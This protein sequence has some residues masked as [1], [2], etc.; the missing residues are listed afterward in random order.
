M[1]VLHIITGLNDGGAEGALF[2][3]LVQDSHNDHI[4]IS[5]TDEGK[6]GPLISRLGIKVHCLNIRNKLLAIFAAPKL[7][8]LLIKTQ[9]DAIQTWMYH[10]DLI[11]GIC[12]RLAGHRNIF[13]GIRNDEIINDGTARVTKYIAYLCGKLSNFIPKKII[14]C[15][16]RAVETHVSKGYARKKMCV[17]QNGFNL[18]NFYAHPDDAFHLRKQLQICNEDTPL[19]GC[20]ARF[21]PQK[22]HENLFGALAILKR[23]NIKFKCVLVGHLMDSFNNELQALIIKYDLHRDIVLLG[24][25]NDIPQIMSALDIHILS[26]RSE[27]FPNVIAEAMACCT[28][29]VSTDVGDARIIIGE[30]GW[31]APTMNAPALAEKLQQALRLRENPVLWENLRK[32]TRQHIIEHFSIEK[33]AEKY[34]NTW[35]NS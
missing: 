16:Y 32:S 23:N 13:W 21:D 31:L 33:M 29:C 26:S 3:L 30:N 1:L 35:A 9:P 12:A 20:V 11:G 34:N 19:F 24:P 7:W 4:V 28:P 18:D 25:R 17:I 10:S 2:R 15:S 8:K 14:S 22:D 6:Y 27:A 5:L